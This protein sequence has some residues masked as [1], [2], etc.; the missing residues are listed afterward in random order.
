[1]AV[2]SLSGDV[3]A[4]CP[5][6]HTPVLTA[7]VLVDLVG[8]ERALDSARARIRD[9]LPGATLVEVPAGSLDRE[10]DRHL[11]AELPAPAQP[12]MLVY[13]FTTAPA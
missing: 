12:G 8:D 11:I 2:V 13:G 4:A 6:G 10:R 5:P 7:Y 9:R 3:A 1:M